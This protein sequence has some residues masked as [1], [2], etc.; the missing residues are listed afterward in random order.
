MCTKREASLKKL[1]GATDSCPKLIDSIGLGGYN[2]D[3]KGGIPVTLGERIRERRTACGLSQEKAAE[4]VGVSRQAVTKWER[5]QAA[6]STENLFKL[7][8]VFGTTVDLLLEEGTSEGAESRAEDL[9]Q[10]KRWKE[11]LLAG[12][13]VAGVYLGTRCV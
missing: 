1:P 5:G 12:L 3:R 11:R 4:L 10:K 13:A 9:G 2:V 7:A 6:P 8:Q